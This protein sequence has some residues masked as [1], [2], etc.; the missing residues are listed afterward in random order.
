VT[1]APVPTSAPV[2][3]EPPAKPTPRPEREARTVRRDT[4]KPARPDLVSKGAEAPSAHRR[5]VVPAGIESEAAI[6]LPASIA[7]EHGN[8]S[9]GLAVV[10][11]EDGSAREVRVISPVCP[12]C[13]RAARAAVLRYRFR[14]ARDAEGKPVESRVAVPVIIPAP[15]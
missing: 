12:E 13:D 7:R 15:E 2:A 6:E 9:V 11:G 1:S 3:D 5:A 8:Q 10:V 14:P 4:E